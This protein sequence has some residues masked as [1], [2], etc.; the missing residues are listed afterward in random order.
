MPGREYL[1]AL[2]GRLGDWAFYSVLMTLEQV[3][4]KVS[5]AK[6][7]HNSAKLSQLIQRELDEK[8]RASQIGNYLLQNE[9]RF[10]NSL[11]V[12]VYDGEPDWHEIQSFRQIANDISAENVSYDSRYSIGFLSFAGGEKLFALDGQ[13]RLAGIRNALKVQPELSSEEVS[14]IVV[15]HRTDVEG[16]KRTR[17]L[18]TTLNKTA[19]PV[20]KS[21]I[22]ALDEAD[23]MAIT[24]RRLVEYDRRFDEK[25]IDILRKNAN[26]PKSDVTHLTT[27]I[28]LYDVLEI[29]F[30]RGTKGGKVG[31]LKRVRPS[32]QELEDYASLA[33][34]YFTAL[35]SAFPRLR[36]CFRAKKPE[37]VIKRHRR[38]TGGEVLFRPVGLL[39]FTDIVATLMRVANKTLHESV[40]E[41]QSLPT[42]LSRYPYEGILW[43]KR[44]RTMN[45]G[46]RALVRDLLLYYLGYIKEATRIKKLQL[47]YAA[48]MGGDAEEFP[49]RQRLGRTG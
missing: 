5:Y 2:R 1:P 3:A 16:L 41:L 17:K 46:G 11:V 31:D 36:E 21:E 29:L 24:A 38:A 9:D 34:E 43:D 19:M 20:S 6:E 47:R 32:D 4:N 10:F 26:L 40:A 30:V 48:K 44:T 27:L 18:F 13:H 15:A 45:T 8:K 25:H 12:A 35:G 22:I 37:S 14:V 28:N 49:L 39:I 33:R 23:A 7:I 42:Q